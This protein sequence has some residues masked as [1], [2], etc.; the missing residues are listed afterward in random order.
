MTKKFLNV[1]QSRKDVTTSNLSGEKTTSI[2][3]LRLW[4]DVE[5]FNL[6]D[7][8]KKAVPLSSLPCLPWEN[9]NERKN[10]KKVQRHTLFIGV[11][12]KQRVI[13]Q[14]NAILKVPVSNEDYQEPII[15]ETCLAALVVDEDGRPDWNSYV[16]TSFIHG[17]YCLKQRKPFSSIS[18]LLGEVQVNFETR[19]NIEKFSHETTGSG[20]LR[21]GDVVSEK[22][23]LREIKELK[24][25]VG[26][27]FEFEEEVYILS[28]EISRESEVEPPFLNSF[29]LEDLNF[30]IDNPQL[31]S[32]AL[33]KYLSLKEDTG[34][35]QDLI[36]NRELLLRTLNPNVLPPGKWP[37][38]VTNGLYTAQQAAIN[39]M[40][41]ELQ[42][43]AGIMSINGPPGT[44]KTTLLLD[45]IA[46]AIVSRAEQLSKLN[47]SEIFSRK[48][49]K[50][51]RENGFT[52]YY[53]SFEDPTALSDHS[54]VI[55]SNNNVAVENI[56]KELPSLGKIDEDVF[57][58]E[59][60]Y[61]SECAGRLLQHTDA[62]GILGAPLGN[63]ENRRAF[64]KNFWESEG[65]L[66]GFQ[67]ILKNAQ[68]EEDQS[69]FEEAFEQTKVELS[70]LFREFDK[71]RTDAYNFHKTTMS[72]VRG[73]HHK[74][75]LT[76]KQYDTMRFKLGN[77]YDIADENIVDVNF[78]NKTHEQIHLSAPYT[79]EYINTL[80]G[81]ILLKSLKLHRY[82]ILSNA[83]QIKNNLQLFFDV[84][85]GRAKIS[86]NDTLT[87]W[88]TFFFCVPV[89]STT[90]A[91]ASRLFKNFKK[92]TIGWLLLD[93]AGQATPQS[94]AGILWR[95]K[96]C[97]VVGDPLQIKPVVIQPEH[98]I[99]MLRAK[100][101]VKDVLWSPLASSAQSLADRISAMGAHKREGE[102]VI[103]S[104]FPL[105]TH[106]RCDNPMFNI[107]NSIAY[108]GQMV[109]ARK[110]APFKCILGKSCWFD[111]NGIQVEDKH[112]IREEI[113][114]LKERI[115]DLVSSGYT[116]N[117]FIIT[118]FVAVKNACEEAVAPLSA[119]SS[120]NQGKIECGTIHTFQGK[121]AEIVFLVLGSDPKKNGAR[122][123]VTQ[124]SNILNVAVTRAQRRIF[125]IGNARLWGNMDFIKQFSEFM[126]IK[127]C[128]V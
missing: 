44:G 23:L 20:S 7:R 73:S 71:F 108:G 58:D 36:A 31:H 119:M 39:T 100:N 126:P 51:E 105:L 19:L 83:K 109:K 77:E 15:G 18:T 106:R 128:D 62:W 48:A 13:E 117:I 37:S 42:G 66:P 69:T 6:P 5:I 79:S 110:D 14:L 56:T 91:S 97:I 68:A 24:N 93:E 3:V 50:V 59:A 46:N 26:S 104:G 60:D 125:I 16:Q 54:I 75:G 98:L 25:I 28:K 112:V 123:W 55:S 85:N 95:A 17:I 94:V 101:N 35:R 1:F 40:V 96:R 32:V 70:D 10:D 113:E 87:L 107:A 9:I 65:L 88:N 47:T 115:V 52:N 114:F 61:F 118:P 27:S 33:N 102:D 64:K 127:K 122:D 90:L 111:I 80:R 2:N 41:A 29:Y 12:Q 72:A 11:L 4:R 89:V 82:A 74:V 53:Y 120:M 76:R 63:K 116:K 103:W 86:N 78:F 121:E 8:D 99:K 22:T 92:E 124:S 21:K 34:N 49:L 84:I 43:K 57:G 38:S 67:Q 30:L 81:R 45:L